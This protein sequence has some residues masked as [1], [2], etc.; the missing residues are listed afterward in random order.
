MAVWTAQAGTANGHQTFFAT[1]DLP[2]QWQAFEA[3][4]LA[5]GVPAVDCQHKE[6]IVNKKSAD[7]Q[8][9]VP[10]VG[11]EESVDKIRDILFGSQM[12]D[13]ERK[14]SQLE[15]R[16]MKEVGR[17]RDE[18]A[19]RLDALEQSLDREFAALSK[20]LGGEH[21][22]R[23]A[24]EQ[25]LSE[26]MASSAEHLQAALAT[27]DEELKQ[28]AGELQQQMQQQ[29]RVLSEE[30][31]A[32]QAETGDRLEHETG[33]LHAQKV[34]RSALSALFN[35]LAARISDDVLQEGDGKA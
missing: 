7:I 9:A 12:R 32:R 6:I 30:I 3:S 22:D 13:Y 35:E 11:G 27:L 25:D 29:S 28:A 23:V 34:D 1:N 4:V 5:P 24:A 8:Q 18:Q 10:D 17:L 31:G 19:Q 33:V 20:R 15:Q 2:R 16:I 21:D 14:F 26:A